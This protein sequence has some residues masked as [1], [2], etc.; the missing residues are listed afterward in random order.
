[1]GPIIPIIVVIY[2]VASVV[3]AV[4]QSL[5]NQQQK[6]APRIPK[7]PPAPR[8][9]APQTVRQQQTAPPDRQPKTAPPAPAAQKPVFEHKRPQVQTAN[10]ADFGF[11]GFDGLN[12]LEAAFDA[13]WDEA[14]PA[15][16][17]AKTKTAAPAKALE[18][19]VVF[20]GLASQLWAGVIYSEILREPRAVRPWP[21]R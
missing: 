17:G 6:G 14:G 13:A 21:A 2:L 20:S 15:A 8:P 4:L 1:M 9:K 12:E 5:Q 3:G 11:E 19:D 10:E 18:A 7:A 16:P